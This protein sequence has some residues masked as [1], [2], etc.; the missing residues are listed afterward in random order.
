MLKNRVYLGERHGIKD[1]CEPII[2]REQFARVQE[3]LLSRSQRNSANSP[4]NIYLFAGLLRCAECGASMHSTTTKGHK[5]YR[6]RQAVTI[7]PVLMIAASG[8]IMWSGG[9][10]QI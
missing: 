4:K 3:L 8:R 9:F 10:W 1:F 2:E 6:C 7:I 5:Y